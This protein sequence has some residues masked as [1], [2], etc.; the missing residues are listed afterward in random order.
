MKTERHPI[1]HI[2]EKMVK[3]RK[4]TTNTSD[5]IIGCENLSFYAILKV[6]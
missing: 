5:N 1:M 4:K 2:C 6:Y 3:D